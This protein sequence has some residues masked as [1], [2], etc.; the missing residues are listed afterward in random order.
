ML[1]I[2]NTKLSASRIAVKIASINENQ[3]CLS[4]STPPLRSACQHAGLLLLKQK[5]QG[6]PVDDQPEG[7]GDIKR[8]LERHRQACRDHLRDH[9]NVDGDNE[10]HRNVDGGPAPADAKVAPNGSQIIAELQQVLIRDKSLADGEDREGRRR[11]WDDQQGQKQPGQAA[12]NDQEGIV[13]K[14]DDSRT[15]DSEGITHGEIH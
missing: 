6:I 2:T 15:N 1:T 8:H 12:E 10:E 9:A 11:A 13:P 7:Q 14:I 5:R 4:S 3:G